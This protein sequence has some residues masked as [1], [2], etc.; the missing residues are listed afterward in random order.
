MSRE[1]TRDAY[2]D[3][4][5]ILHWLSAVLI[6]LM[7][8]LGFAMQRI[9][10]QSLQLGAMRFHVLLGFVVLGLTL[11]R[12]VWRWVDDSPDPLPDL[13]DLHRRGIGMVHV[14]L[15]LLLAGL[16]I[17]G[18]LL[19]VQSGLGLTLMGLSGDPVPVNLSESL[20]RQAHGLEARVYIA[21]LVAHLGGIVVYQF[22]KGDVLSRM[23]IRM[24]TRVGE[25]R[26]VPFAP[27]TRRRV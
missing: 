3:R 7:I 9:E 8:P 14:L 16:S 22:S 20:P 13:S 2:S 15:Y 26:G 25:Q 6:L 27:P 23:G 17:S 1:E 4:I 12:V 24:G 11:L 21:L 18:V 10:S 19:L 5:Q